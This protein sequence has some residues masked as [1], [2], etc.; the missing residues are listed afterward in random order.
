MKQR[1]ILF[2]LFHYINGKLFEENTLTA[3]HELYKYFE[4]TL[5]KL[6]NSKGCC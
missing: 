2:I 4:L 5:V 3:A 6:K 1:R